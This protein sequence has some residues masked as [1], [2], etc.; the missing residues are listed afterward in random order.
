MLN[1]DRMETTQ[2]WPH[3]LR[4]MADD[5]SSGIW[6]I[7]A[8]PEEGPFRHHM[9]SYEALGLPKDLVELFDMWIAVYNAKFDAP[10]KFDLD[11]HNTEGR[12]LALALKHHV[13][14]DTRVL[15]APETKVERYGGCG[16]DE[17]IC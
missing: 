15:F 14:S 2:Q 3:G 1:L 8:L 13:G 17:E 10:E 12:A 9:I 4:V 11:G 7:H 16:P 5:C 6:A